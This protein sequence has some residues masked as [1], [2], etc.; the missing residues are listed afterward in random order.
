MKDLKDRLEKLRIEA[1]SCELI[2]KLATDQT[3]REFFAQLAVQLRQMAADVEKA[4]E[5]GRGGTSPT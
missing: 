1:E 4:I 5:A 3:K 2:G